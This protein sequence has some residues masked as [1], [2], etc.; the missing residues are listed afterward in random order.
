MKTEAD[1]M[2]NKIIYIL[3]HSYF[4]EKENKYG[5]RPGYEE[6]KMLGLYSTREKAEL[7]I[8]DYMRKEGFNKYGRESFSIDPY[9]IDCDAGWK[10]GFECRGGY[11][12]LPIGADIADASLRRTGPGSEYSK[13]K[14][15]EKS[16][17][18]KL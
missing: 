12:W 2:N 3:Q 17:S 7:A 9:E 15:W 4:Y 16:G 8:D 13:I 18:E 6:V 1:D 14:I 10:S 11:Y 5:I